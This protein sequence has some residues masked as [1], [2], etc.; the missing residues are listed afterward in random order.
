MRA[1]SISIVFWSRDGFN[2]LA[3][4]LAQKCLVPW[5]QGSF[6]RGHV[7]TIDCGTQA[8]PEPFR[9][10]VPD[11]VRRRKP[12]RRTLL[13]VHFGYRDIWAQALANQNYH[14]RTP[15]A[16]KHSRGPRKR[17]PGVALAIQRAPPVSRSLHRLPHDR[18]ENDPRDSRGRRPAR[19]AT[20]LRCKRGR[21]LPQANPRRTRQ[22]PRTRSAP[23]LAGP[24]APP[25]RPR[26]VWIALPLRPHP[27]P[28]PWPRSSPGRGA[29]RTC[30]QFRPRRNPCACVAARSSRPTR[31]SDD[32]QASQ[33]S[34]EPAG[35]E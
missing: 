35:A 7:C 6:A 31:R 25:C 29:A 3:L 27:R 30:V 16:A 14:A 32:P 4:H 15:S 5:P 10:P 13:L 2:D 18:S 1:L 8:S 24:S 11:C 33:G 23:R 19:P 26:R 12:H 28:H 20:G 21:T 17:D 9:S 22:R 34:D